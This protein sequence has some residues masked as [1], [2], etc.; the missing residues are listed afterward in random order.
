MATSVSGLE[1]PQLL[2][3]VVGWLMVLA[4][5]PLSLGY[6]WGSLPTGRQPEW[7]LG[8]YSDGGFASSL[9]GWRQASTV[10]FGCFLV[11]LQFRRHLR[12]AA[13][14]VIAGLTC[15]HSPG[16]RQAFLLC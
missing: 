12:V 15:R 3:P 5:G 10:G 8:A 16:W 6:G 2:P 13:A 14:I 1:F 9:P 4:A 7:V 11:Y